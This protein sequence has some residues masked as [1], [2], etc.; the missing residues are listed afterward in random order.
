MQPTKEDCF[1][2]EGKLALPYQYFAGRT[3]SR[4]LIA[5]RDEKKIRG[6]RCEKCNKVFVPPRS[7]CERC[8][9]DI[10]QSWVDLEDTGTVTGFTV[11]RYEEP[12]QPTKPP[13]ILALIKLDGA[14]TPIAHIIK[15]IPLT[16]M[17]LGLKVKAVFAEKTTSTIMD[18]D[19]F[20]PQEDG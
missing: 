3:G 4:F 2:V 16:E 6:I 13:Y 14:D 5:L 11:V 20:R 18:I 8:F 15:D 12:Y 17:K 7:T 9:S 1:I 19:H 10:S